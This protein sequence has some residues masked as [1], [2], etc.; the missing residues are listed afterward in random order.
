M[1]TINGDSTN[2]PGTGA[3]ITDRAHDVMMEVATA[4]RIPGMTVAIATPDALL[5][6]G[7]VGHADLA[8]RRPASVHDQY[9]WFS[10][11]KIATATTAIRLHRAGV[12]DL[13]AP[14]GGYLPDYRPHPKHGHPT[15]RHLL[16]HT[17]GLSNPVPVRWVRLEHQPADAAAIAKI[18]AKHGTP[19]R[20]VGKKASY[21]NIGYLLAGE[22]IAAASGH[23]VED[24]VR[25]HVLQPLSMTTTGYD[26]QPDAPRS[27]GYVRLPRPAVPLLRAALPS[28][29][30][31]HRV[32]G[33]SALNPFLIN[34]A[35]FGGL[36]GTVT[37]AARLAAVHAAQPHHPERLLP[38]DEIES[39][40]TIASPGKR[41]DHGIGWFRKPDDAHRTPGFVEHYGTGCGYWNAMRIYPER[42]LAMVAMTNTT[43]AWDVDRLFT[44]LEELS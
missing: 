17:A 23:S 15:M 6:A 44:R 32:A 34:G 8:D 30:V 28:G 16:T 33:R 7:A 2:R 31:G 19:V 21:S 40:R 18:V 26:H 36:I 1:N 4:H 9:P 42:R 5:Y 39:M 12:L 3:G 41:F 11:T 22:V 24:N 13:D 35:A 37:D 29:L 43:Y 27:V 20:A 14:I 25:H 38:H 10:M